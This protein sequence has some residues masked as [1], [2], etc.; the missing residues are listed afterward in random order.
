MIAK[1]MFFAVIALL[2]LLQPLIATAQFDSLAHGRS[3]QYMMNQYFLELNLSRLPSPFLYEKAIPGVNIDLWHH[4]IVDS[5]VDYSAF[6]QFYIDMYNAATAPNLMLPI[7]SLDARLLAFDTSTNAY[8]TVQVIPLGIIYTVVSRIKDNAYDNMQLHWRD[9]FLV[10]GPDTLSNPYYLDTVWIAAPLVRQVY[11][12]KFKLILRPQFIFTAPGVNINSVTVDVNDGHGTRNLQVGTSIKVEVDTLDTLINIDILNPKYNGNALMG[13]GGHII[14]RLRVDPPT[15]PPDMVC[16]TMRKRPMPCGITDLYTDADAAIYVKFSHLNSHRSSLKFNKTLLFI[17]G[18]D[19]ILDP[20]KFVKPNPSVANDDGIRGYGGIGWNQFYSGQVDYEYPQLQFT[21]YFIDSANKAGYD[22]IAVDFKNGGAMIQK[23]ANVLMKII[24]YVNDNRYGSEPMV[25]VGCSMGGLVSRYALSLMEKQGCCHNVRLFCT[26]D[27]PHQGADISPGLEQFVNF[28]KDNSDKAMTGYKEITEDGP[29]QMMLFSLPGNSCMVDTMHTQWQSTLNSIGYPQNLRKITISNGSKT[30]RTIFDSFARFIKYDYVQNHLPELNIHMYTWALNGVN[31]QQPNTVFYGFLD[32]QPYRTVKSRKFQYSV[33]GCNNLYYDNC[34]GSLNDPYTDVIGAQYST[35]FTIGGNYQINHFKLVWK[36]SPVVIYVGNIYAENRLNSFIPTVHALDIKPSVWNGNLWYDIKN[37]IV[38]SIPQRD[39]YPFDAYY[40]PDTPQWHVNVDN[41][42]DNRSINFNDSKWLM[43]QIISGEYNLLSTLPNVHGSLYNV[44]LFHNQLNS[45]DI[46]NGGSLLI[47]KHGNT[48]YG[49]GVSTTP[50]NLD[51]YTGSCV[52]TVT[53]DSGG[54]MMLGDSISGNED[55]QATVRIT[56]GNKLVI[57]KGGTIIVNN[58]ST[59]KIENGAELDYNGGT[60]VLMGSNAVLEIDGK[61]VVGNNATFTFKN[62]TNAHPHSWGFMRVVQSTPGSNVDVGT[63]SKIYIGGA[64]VNTKLL[65][66]RG[67]EGFEPDASLAL[68]TIENAKVEMDQSCRLNIKCPITMNYTNVDIY[69]GA[70]SGAKH[71]GIQTYGQSGINLSNVTAQHGDYGFYAYSYGGSAHNTANV[72]GTF[73]HNTKGLFLHDVPL[74]FTGGT[75]NNNSDYGILIEGAGYGCNNYVNGSMNN[76]GITGL[77]FTGGATGNYMHFSGNL[78]TNSYYG[79]YVEQCTY[80]SRCGNYYQNGLTNLYADGTDIELAPHVSSGITGDNQ[81][82][83]VNKNIDGY[84]A[85][86]LKLAHGKNKFVYGPYPN[87]QNIF[88]NWGSYCIWPTLTINATQ[89]YWKYSGSVRTSISSPS[90]YNLHYTCSFPTPGTTYNVNLIDSSLM[91]A[92][93]NSAFCSGIGMFIANKGD[94]TLSGNT[95]ITSRGG[96]ISVAT[97]SLYKS[98]HSYIWLPTIGNAKNKGSAMSIASDVDGIETDSIPT[99][100]VTHLSSLLLTQT[101]SDLVRDK[102]LIDLAYKKAL[103]GFGK[104]VLYD[105]GHK[106]KSTKKSKVYPLLHSLQ[107]H[108]LNES[109]S[110][111]T[112]KLDSFKYLRDEATL[113]REEGK[114]T[115]ALLLMD[116]IKGFAP[117]SELSYLNQWTCWLNNEIL[118]SKGLIKQDNFDKLNRCDRPISRP[119]IITIQNN[120]AG[121]PSGNNVSNDEVTIYPNPTCGLLNAEFS[122]AK[123]EEVSISIMDIR[124]RLV[125]TQNF[126]LQNLGAKHLK[127]DVKGLSP[128][129]YILNVQTPTSH[130]ENKFVV[131]R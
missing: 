69:A 64:D 123:T 75:A 108:L 65:E 3:G 42:Y 1:K 124:G 59:L 45:L 22:V 99:T 32:E 121:I 10:D 127:L 2:C 85:I 113:Y 53:V 112:A 107:R 18:L 20:P 63:N 5:F 95:G 94:T 14:S 12:N 23:N 28:S 96:G 98:K 125:Q 48:D 6:R 61:I 73:V 40:A 97:G 57:N 30:R 120:S 117:Q 87:Y 72:S 15:A 106:T 116:S 103:E 88:V 131:N 11:G 76:N 31:Y 8:D 74:N 104:M 84:N 126:G 83:S 67:G 56:S 114:L 4:G 33:G 37:N 122:L 82:N 68:L 81:F 60:I 100:N 27:S 47:N 66:I 19:V 26:W 16:D 129:I 110:L 70:A 7:D 119:A 52:T 105:N 50:L 80:Y 101:S 9:S 92:W 41:I 91:S 46:Q 109:K 102:E 34:P 90:D 128:G 39:L 77:S 17:E 43:N 93:D 38:P 115:E 24:R 36:S 54:V 13:G 130:Y 25:V 89:N 44:G 35:I 55:Y 118:I 58:N 78:E 86:T 71:R 21:K 62:S 49:A 29:R 79:A 111:P 51:V